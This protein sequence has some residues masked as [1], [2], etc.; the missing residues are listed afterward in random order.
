MNYAL[1]LDHH[2]YHFAE[3]LTNEDK[4]S[5]VQICGTKTSKKIKSL[6][7]ICAFNADPTTLAIAA[8]QEQIDLNL[9]WELSAEQEQWAWSAL[10]ELYFSQQT[11]TQRLALFLALTALEIYFSYQGNQQF[12]RHNA[13]EVAKRQLQQQRQLD[14][15][16]QF[17][18]IYDQL[19][20]YQ[21]PSWNIDPL[22]LLH[23]PDKNSIEY[24]AAQ[25]AAKDLK[26]SLAELYYKLG[27]INS[28][29]ELMLTTFQK[30]YFPQ[31]RELAFMPI[32]DHAQEIK[33]NTQQR[34]FSIDDSFTT[35]IDDAFSVT[36][37]PQG[38]LIGIHIAAPAL[39][40]QLLDLASERLSTVYYPGH[41]ITMLP[42]NIIAHYSLEEGKCLPV[43]SI[44]FTLDQELNIT[45]TSTQLER[46]M[47]SSN[48]RIESL[49]RLF[50]G[51]NLNQDHDYPYEPELK[52]L[53]KFALSLEEKR[54]KPSVNQL[55]VD[56]NF[57]FNPDGQISIKPRLRG[58][59]IDKLVSELMILANCSW[60]RLLTN[61]F[62]PAIYRVK[63]PQ[64]AVVM[65]TTP[66]SHCGL[67]VDYYTWA[68][69]PLRR[70][71][72]LVNQAQIISLITASKP[73]TTTD[74]ALAN[75]VE[76]F[77]QTYSAYL[78][79]QDS[80]ERYWSLRY[81]EQQKITQI[82]ATFTFR[83]KVQLDG[84]PIILDISHLTAAQ[85][86]GSDLTLR[87]DNI[88]CF[89]QTFTYQLATTNCG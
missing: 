27:Y 87:I 8:E 83:S 88:N 56:Y 21:L 52:L 34:I 60:G 35:E 51:A 7:V 37:M 3:L 25:Q 62:I 85:A 74:Y 81:F 50:N 12:K 44:Y 5:L 16:T 79:F 42:E 39:N 64:Q 72:D 2:H 20:N 75:I 82:K 66:N 23:A 77:D 45:A 40:R 78:K 86:P 67:N 18:A 58:N 43:V 24:K 49:E 69:S 54:G 14:Y 68:S 4:Y 26:L 89:N 65:T 53:Y 71:V 10:V 36:P 59:P 63:Q 57:S 11:L 41:K 47:I 70:A 46:V 17:N 55:T 30:T 76:N 9:L 73:L 32:D 13:T 38:W 31:G 80:M 29:E 33:L 22:S 28:I 48:L 6:N 19:Y 84:V 61:A 1:I 15:Q